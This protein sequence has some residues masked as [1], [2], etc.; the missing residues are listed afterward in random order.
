MGIRMMLVG[1][2][3]GCDA[4]AAPYSLLLIRSRSSMDMDSLAAR[5]PWL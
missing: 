4:T 2:A 1:T 3:L 5:Q